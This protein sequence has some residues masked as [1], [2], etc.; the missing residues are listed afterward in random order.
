VLLLLLQG[1]SYPLRLGY[2]VVI[3][4][5]QQDI[6]KNMSAADAAAKEAHFFANDAFFSGDLRLSRAVCDHFGVD[7]LRTQLSKQLV[8]LTQR[9]LPGMKHALEHVLAEVRVSSVAVW[10][11]CWFSACADSARAAW[12]EACP[13]GEG[14]G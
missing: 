6:N 3:N 8:A 9:E 13:G 4:P 5:S 12:D 2:Y 7:A 14:S 1:E 10:C 11:M